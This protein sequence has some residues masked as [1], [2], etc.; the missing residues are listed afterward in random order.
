L[1]DFNEILFTHEKEGGN[2]RPQPYMQSFRDVLSECALEDLGFSGNPFTWKRG[3]IRERLDRAVANGNWMIMHPGATLQHLEFT[4]SDHR[5]ILLDT[6]YQL[7]VGNSRP[8]PKR[9]EAK[10]FREEG[11]CQEVQ[12]AWDA[13]ADPGSDGVLPRLNRMHAALHAWDMQVVRK[14][15]GRLR[16]A[17]K[18]LEQ[19]L[20]GPL[21][22]ENDRKAKELANLVELL[23]EQEEVYWSQRSRANWL[24]L[25]DRNTTFFHNFAS[26]HRKKNM[27]KK[28]K[29]N[30]GIWV[31]G[32]DLLKPLVFDYFSNLFSSEV[33]VTDQAV[34][35]KIAPRITPEMNEKLLAPFSAED[36]KKAAFS[37]GDYKAP[38]PDGLHAIFYKKFWSICGEDITTEI[39]LAM[40]TGVIPE[41]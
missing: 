38:G 19:A 20:N 12:R 7:P 40:H 25:G 16:K 34:L 21:S 11:F 27:I 32:T 18:Q 14:P 24:Q 26:A 37:I 31:E 2:Q 30:D 8:G 41:G 35:E 39:L 1:G 4:R 15:K 13:A 33:Q 17:Q 10:W 6:D 36:V 5:P 3:M 29:D 28:L 23:L 9:F 22:A